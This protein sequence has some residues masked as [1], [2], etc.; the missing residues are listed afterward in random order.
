M[1]T[2]T[3]NNVR[4]YSLLHLLSI[5][6]DI[7]NKKKENMSEA[8]LS[9]LI[10]RCFLWTIHTQKTVITHC[11][12]NKYLMKNVY[13]NRSDV[14]MYC[15]F[16]IVVSKVIVLGDKIESCVL[17]LRSTPVSSC[18]MCTSWTLLLD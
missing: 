7:K 10:V 18:T 4:A 2:S 3:I 1:K 9:K 13:A 6:Y 11:W 16:K 14:T 17:L 15:I 5:L 12:Q 8:L